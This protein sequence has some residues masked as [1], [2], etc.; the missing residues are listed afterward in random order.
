MS[1]AFTANDSRLITAA[2]DGAITQ[3]STE[4]TGDPTSLPPQSSTIAQVSID[5]EDQLLSIALRDGTT[6]LWS[7]AKGSELR[8][9]QQNDA[10]KSTAFSPDGLQVISAGMD[11]VAQIWDGDMGRT[12]HTLWADP[13]GIGAVAFSPDGRYLVTAGFSGTARF[14]D[15]KSG[16][17]LLTM[18]G[19]QAGW[20]AVAFPPYA[21]RKLPHHVAL[22]SRDGTVR[23]FDLELPDL[24]ARAQ[25]LLKKG[26]KTF[27]NDDCRRYLHVKACPA[28][29]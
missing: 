2:W 13:D 1:V 26:P 5:F 18:A 28:E 12:V 24:I 15:A 20:T 14:W 21:Q 9:F 7:L 4:S 22:A 6:R 17:E 23:F 10:L 3:W 8:S 25:K 27:T 29:P 16:E 19:F 11:G